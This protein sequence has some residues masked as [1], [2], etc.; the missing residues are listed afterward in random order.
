MKIE[1]Y[2][3]FVNEIIDSFKCKKIIMATS[4]RVNVENGTDEDPRWSEVLKERNSFIKEF[5]LKNNYKLNNL[6]ELSQ[7]I[8]NKDRL[9]DGYHYQVSGYEIF[10]E[11]IVKYIR[12]SLN[13]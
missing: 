8:D 13:I 5:S 1:D 6:N 7:K 12:N 3:K 10:A 4:T 2:E 11:Q 9:T